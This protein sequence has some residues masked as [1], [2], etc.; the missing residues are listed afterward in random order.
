ML[1]TTGEAIAHG[2]RDKLHERADH[3]VAKGQMSKS[4]ADLRLKLACSRWLSA[5]LRQVQPRTSGSL[6]EHGG[7][8]NHFNQMANQMMEN[9]GRMMQ[10]R[11]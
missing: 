2:D 3:T 8:H 7:M 4:R 6:M 9:M 1:L 5:S 11:K 10:M